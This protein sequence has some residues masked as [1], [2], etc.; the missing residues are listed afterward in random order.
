MNRHNALITLTIAAV[1]G[2]SWL[3]SV[4]A[5]DPEADNSA[6]NVRDRTSKTMTA[7]RQTEGSKSDVDITRE[8]RRAITKDDSFSSSARNVKI[9]TKSGIVNLRGPVSNAAESEKIAG[10]AQKTAG[11]TTV[12]NDLEVKY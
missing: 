3:P 10:L 6:K 11:V 1:A 8:I 2:I 12:K 4:L 5:E 9:V 7:D